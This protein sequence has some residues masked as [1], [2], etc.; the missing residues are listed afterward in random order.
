MN[1]FFR[2]VGNFSRLTSTASTSTPLERSTNDMK[3][4]FAT[5]LEDS[6]V[7]ESSQSHID[8]MSFAAHELLDSSTIDSISKPKR[9]KVSDA[10]VAESLVSTMSHL[11]KYMTAAKPARSR[12]GNS[13]D[14]LLQC[15]SPANQVKAENKI[16]AFLCKCKLK[17]FEKGDV[18]DVSI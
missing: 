14:A 2:T 17:D 1:Q 10:D 9:Q 11:Q 15:L 13:I 5:Y 7:D 3:D 6:D 18:D 12:A 8:E 16:M 4:M